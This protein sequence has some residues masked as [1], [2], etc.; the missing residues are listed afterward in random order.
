MSE[1]ITFREVKLEG[2]WLMVKPERDDLGKAMAVVRKHKD[3]L[4]TLEIK[5]Y[6]KKRSLDANAKLWALINEMS[7]ILRLTP[8]EI[9]QGYIPDV[10]NN[11]KYIPALP[12]EVEE[13]TKDWCKGHIGRMVED[14]GPCRTQ[15]LRGHRL[16]KMYR[17]ISRLRGICP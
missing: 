9:Y 8:E 4:Y 12:E 10:G 11:F 13:W 15:A 6:R 1:T 5:E 3:R 2:G 7:T 14:V 17:G 16:L